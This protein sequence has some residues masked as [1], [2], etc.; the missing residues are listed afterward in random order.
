[1]HGED[2]ARYAAGAMSFD[3][4]ASAYDAFRGRY[5]RLLV[6]QMVDLAGLRDGARVIDVGCGPGALTAELVVRLGAGSVSAVD[7]SE[8]FVV[9]A[10]E[11][12]P[13][14]DVRRAGAESLPYP[15]AHFDAAF[16]Q[17]V[18]HFM[19]DPV[20]GIREMA[21]VTRPGGAVVAC[22]W[23]L[24]GGRSPMS[25][26][27]SAVA[28]QEPRH[29]GE[30][31]LAGTRRGHLVELFEA[32]GLADVEEHVLEAN[33]THPTFED[34]WVPFTGGVGP[35]GAHLRSLEPAKRADLERRVRASVPVAPFTIEAR[36]WAARGRLKPTGASS[37]P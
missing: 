22:V 23:D 12:L 16:A 28:D 20:A 19:T 14:V 7:P 27:W 8:P 17:L 18:V 3:V 10:T 13:G 26:F 11:R 32:A 25:I 35:A 24:E 31:R 33:I 1:M 6:G 4:A 36:A 37:V 30:S 29:A 21:R 9:A 5:S 15:D 34:W 2:L